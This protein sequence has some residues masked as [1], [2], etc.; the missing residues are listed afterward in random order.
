[1]T[2]LPNLNSRAFTDRPFEHYAW[3]REHAPAYDGRVSVLRA[4]LLSRYDDCVAMLKD[5][6]FVRNRGTVMG[7]R[8]TPI[9]LPRSA[10]LLAESMIVDDDPGHRRVRSL[11]QKAFTSR[12]LAGLDVRVERL[13]HQLLDQAEKR[14]TVDLIEA[15]ALPIPVTVIRE[16]IGVSEEDMPRFRGSLR[17]LSEGMTGWNVLRTFLWDLPATVRFVREMIERKRREPADDLLTSLIEVEESGDRLSENELLSLVF[18]LIIAGFETTVHA[19]SNG[20][21]ALLQH[22]EQL[23]RLRVDPSLMESAVEEM[24][25]YCGPI[26][27]T[28]PGYA[29]EHLTLHGVKVRRGTMVMPILA[30][31]NRD[32]RVFERPEVFDVARTPNR[33]LGFG[34]GPHFCLG[35]PLARMEMRVAIS[36]L[37]ERCPELRLAV[38]PSALRR[39][40]LLLW[41]RYERLPVTLG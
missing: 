25:R 11:V 16:L 8:R 28:K 19:I 34:H 33:H 40:K 2:S 14:G 9:P 3:L 6:R 20:V 30:A 12:S 22:P 17:V 31:A 15:Y 39:Q 4:V 35:A 24:L 5:P 32:P 38:D 26:H 27:G 36:T 23:A 37:L 29:R 10:A 1:M 41:H 18:L 7:G 13:T 21:L